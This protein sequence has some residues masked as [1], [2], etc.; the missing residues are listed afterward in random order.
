MD[1]I[2]A[3]QG[4]REQIPAHWPAEVTDLIRRCWATAPADRPDMGEVAAA[5]EGFRADNSVL[6]R[7]VMD[8]RLPDQGT[9]S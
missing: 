6:V 2:R 1:P 4:H 5:L 9:M 3:A 8:C 7:L